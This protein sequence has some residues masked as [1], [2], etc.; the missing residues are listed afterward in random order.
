MAKADVIV[1]GADLA[2]LV[3]ANEV[4]ARGRSVLLLDQDGSQSLGGQALWS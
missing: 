4:V 3:A 2:G 1:V